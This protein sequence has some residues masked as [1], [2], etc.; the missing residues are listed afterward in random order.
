MYP[1]YWLC[2]IG[3]YPR[4]KTERYSKVLEQDADNWAKEFMIKNYLPVPTNFEDK[5]I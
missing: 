1:K 4:L 2:A 5:L 3:L